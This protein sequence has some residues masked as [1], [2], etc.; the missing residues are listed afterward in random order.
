[1]KI[2]GKIDGCADQRGV[3]MEIRLYNTSK[4]IE[5]SYN[6]VKL[7][8]TSPEG[9]FIAFP[10][11]MK[12]NDK[13]SFDVQG[14]IVSPG[15][16]QLEGTSAD[17]NVVQNFASVKNDEAQIL[18][19]SNDVPLVQFGD[20]NTGR[21]YYKHQPEK[22]H[23]YS[24]VLNN[25]WT[26]NFRA[27]QQGEMKWR[28]YLT[29]SSNISNSFATKFGWDSRVPMLARVI[30]PKNS[31]TTSEVTSRSLMDLDVPNLLLVNA[32]PS[33]LV[34]GVILHLREMEG[35]HAI[36]DIQ[37]LLDQTGAIQAFEVN[38]L[39]EELKQLTSPLLIEH[40]ETKFILLKE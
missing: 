24:W 39:G 15:I 7:P 33:P 2:N 38:V 29:S 5:L 14:G 19:S 13:L 3:E 10:F 30:P 17:W 21:F 9:V 28:Y 26:T 27:S 8:V 20:I 6:M 35:D 16:N 12:D 4:R 25:Y 34:N 18:Y 36:L 23:I 31:K 32:R 40:F 1:V 11:K 37:K 22:P